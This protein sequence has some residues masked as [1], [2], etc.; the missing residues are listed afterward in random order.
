M[1]LLT[2]TVAKVPSHQ[3]GLLAAVSWPAALCRFQDHIPYVEPDG[4]LMAH[5]ASQS[6]LG[7]ILCHMYIRGGTGLHTGS[8][9]HGPWPSLSIHNYICVCVY[10]GSNGKYH[11]AGLW[12]LFEVEVLPAVGCWGL[13]TERAQ[14]NVIL[15]CSRRCSSARPAAL[16]C[17]T[18]GPV[19]LAPNGNPS[20]PVSLWHSPTWA[21][22]QQ[23]LKYLI[24]KPSHV[25]SFELLEF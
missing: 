10:K 17:G 24:I 15:P 22:L 16:Y 7:A 25:P 21:R 13:L 2:R 11:P 14:Q 3:D 23:R 12:M 18:G 5:F 8:C 4:R 9:I 19:Q 20:P 1:F 6:K